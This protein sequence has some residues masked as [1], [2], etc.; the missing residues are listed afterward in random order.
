MTNAEYDR[1]VRDLL[2]ESGSVSTIEGFGPDSWT[3]SGF[4]YQ[5]APVSMLRQTQLAKAANDLAQNAV[6]H[7]TQ[8]LPCDPA[9]TGGVPCTCG[10]QF[11]D[12]FGPRAFRRPLTLAESTLYGQVF[13]NGCGSDFRSGIQAVIASMLSS[14]SFYEILQERVP[15]PEQPDILPLT[16]YELASR[17][18]YF[19]YRSMPDA[20]LFDAAAGGRLVTKADVE[21]EARRMLISPKAHDA[22]TDFF[23]EWLSLDRLALTEKDPTVLPTFDAVRADMATETIKFT[24]SIFFGDGQLTSLLQSSTTWINEPLA[25]LYAQ[26]GVVGMPFQQI[27]LDPKT[28]AGILTQASFLSLASN[29]S[30]TSPTRRGKFVREKLLCQ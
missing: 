20:A 16:P 10:M 4:R 9:M 14:P 29:A 15:D 1:T 27:K 7:L 8:I 23:A 24:E 21:R 2:G 25:Q 6:T 13:A 11:I 22:V 3:D 18:S 30:R 17:L 12:T 28:R 5:P 19:I 26:P